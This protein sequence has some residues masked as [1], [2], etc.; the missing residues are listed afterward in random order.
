MSDHVLQLEDG[1]ELH[2][3]RVSA[4]FTAGPDGLERVANAAIAHAGAQLPM[5]VAAAMGRRLP[6]LVRL[7]GEIGIAVGAEIVR[8]PYEFRVVNMHRALAFYS[9]HV[10]A[11]QQGMA[12][13]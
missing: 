9:E 12:S 11:I 5:L 7:I 10:N 3:P 2:L 6:Q 4:S 1:T 13:G 8:I